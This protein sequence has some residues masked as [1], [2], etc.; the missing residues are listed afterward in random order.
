[1][2]KN[3]L[4][5]FILS[6]C[7]SGIIVAEGR[8]IAI[9]IDDLP[10]VGSCNGQASKLEREKER[11][12]LIMQTLIDKK[13]PA[14]GFVIAGSIEKG[15]WELLEQFKQRGFILGNHTYSHKSLNSTSAPNYIEDIDRADKILTPLYTEHK[16]F[17]YPYLAE[18]KGTKSQEVHN[19][20]AEHHYT[21]APVTIDSKDFLFNAQL[22]AIPFRA[23][24]QSLPQMKKRYLSYIWN[25]TLRAENRTKNTPDKPAKQIL[26]IHSNLLN[27]HFLGDII[28]MYQQNGYR[29]ISLDEALDGTAP[30]IS[31][32]AAPAISYEKFE[33]IFDNSAVSK[34]FEHY[35]P[36]I[37]TN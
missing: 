6:Y 23:R 7:F 18:S 2:V 17:R 10:F 3:Y 35:K 37:E 26:L 36:T 24:P 31:D 12:L 11:F 15:Q 9:T 29:F 32:T 20:L 28:D 27:S 22:F 25:Q 16:Y 34:I 1:M 30:T 4:A 21:I 8:E 5:A 19:Y 33:M 14:T 13:V